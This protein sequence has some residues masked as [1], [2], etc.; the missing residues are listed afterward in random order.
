[1]K[2]N[3]LSYKHNFPVSVSTT[4]IILV[5]SKIIFMMSSEWK[6]SVEN[7]TTHSQPPKNAV[8]PASPSLEKK[9]STPVRSLSLVKNIL[10]CIRGGFGS[11]ESAGHHP[12]S[13]PVDLNWGNYSMM[14]SVWSC[15]RQLICIPGFCLAEWLM[16]QVQAGTSAFFC[17]WFKPRLNSLY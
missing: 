12:V 13:F 7:Y 10:N 17:P 5:V 3:I 14:F 11:P 15:K 6:L 16:S 8:K 2:E 9:K 4:N 1:M